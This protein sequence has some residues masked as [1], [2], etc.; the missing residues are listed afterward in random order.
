M[1]SALGRTAPK[2]QSKVNQE[3]TL[4]TLRKPWIVKKRTNDTRHGTQ[5]AAVTN[6]E[7]LPLEMV[8]LHWKTAD[9]PTI[10]GISQ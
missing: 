9:C 2:T 1:T 7:E 3:F 10:R 5:K 4:C 6:N 8:I